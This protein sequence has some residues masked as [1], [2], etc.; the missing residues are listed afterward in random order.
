MIDI[1]FSVHA[2]VVV[3]YLL[4]LSGGHISHVRI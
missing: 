2:A 1:H 3:E 4:L